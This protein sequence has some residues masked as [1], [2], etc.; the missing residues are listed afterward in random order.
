MAMDLVAFDLETTGIDCFNDV[1]V[2]YTIGEQSALVNPGRTIPETA[3]NV[4]HITDDMVEDAMDLCNSIFVIR[5]TLEEHWASGKAVIG[6]NVSYDLT[7]VNYVLKQFGSFL[8]VCGPVVD[9]LVIDRTFDKYRKGPR[10]LSAL[11]THYGVT[12]EDAHTSTADA[13][14]CVDV[15]A[16]QVVRFPKLKLDRSNCNDNMAAWYIEWL[17]HYSEWRVKN[18]QDPIPKSHYSWPIH[19]QEL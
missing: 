10:T 2:S 4:H 16:K 9:V 6:M 19:N 14:A 13:N 7:M 1:P 11:C 18:G 3:S 17:T 5:D 15:F 12:L 8:V